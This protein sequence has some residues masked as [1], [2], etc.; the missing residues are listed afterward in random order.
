M[1]QK[2]EEQKKAGKKRYLSPLVV[3]YSA[4]QLLELLGPAQGYGGST[5]QGGGGGPGKGPLLKF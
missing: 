4:R 3:S 5:T 1:A 2:R